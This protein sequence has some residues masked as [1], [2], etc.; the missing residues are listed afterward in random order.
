LNVLHI[1]VNSH[2]VNSWPYFLQEALSIPNNIVNT[3]YNLQ[4][5]FLRQ[6]QTVE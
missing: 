2:Y 5:H 3:N 1:H 6:I 4:F